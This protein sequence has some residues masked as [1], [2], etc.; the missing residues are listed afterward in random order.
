MKKILT[1]LLIGLI[2]LAGCS[3]DSDKKDKGTIVAG[4]TGQSYPNSYEKDGKLVGYDIEAFEKIAHEAG[5]KVKWVKADFSGLMGQLESGRIDTI[6]NA[7]A[8]TDERKEKY[9]FTDAYSYIGSQII[10]SAKN[11]DI[12]SYK[13]LRGKKVAGV[14]GSNHT[15][16]L[17]KFNKENNYGFK[18]KTY[19]NREGALLDLENQR[20]DGYVNSDSVSAADKNKR[21]KDI[22]FVGKPFNVV[23]TSFPF[24]KENKDLKEDI[25]KG[26]KKL[27]KDGTLSDLSDKYFGTD[28]TKEK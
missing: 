20:L 2:V 22:K 13:D 5:Y 15:E 11:K 19:E 7:V 8:T 9:L 10:T 23:G 3:N 17:E 6:A 25:D 14:L 18:T 21:G 16:A 4:T 1:F 28:T 24:T 27:K 26:V 12:N